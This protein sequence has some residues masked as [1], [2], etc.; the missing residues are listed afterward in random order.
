MTK[1][2]LNSRIVELNLPAR[3]FSL[4]SSWKIN[5]KV[6]WIFSLKAQNKEVARS[7]VSSKIS[8]M[9]AIKSW[10]IQMLLIR[11]FILEK[12]RNQM[13]RYKKYFGGKGIQ[14]KT[15]KATVTAIQIKS[16]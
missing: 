14:G 11:N 4:L 12:L 1:T 15:W 5:R 10:Q 9:K 6:V 7:S 8:A 16:I 3:D 2:C 13:L